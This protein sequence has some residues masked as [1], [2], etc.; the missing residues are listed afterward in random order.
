MK[1]RIFRNISSEAGLN[2]FAGLFEGTAFVVDP[3]MLMRAI[4]LLVTGIAVCPAAMGL[5]VLPFEMGAQPRLAPPLSAAL[6]NLVSVKQKAAGI[7]RARM[8]SDEVFLRRLLSKKSWSLGL[9]PAIPYE[10]AEK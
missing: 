3:V 9:L 2:P 8:C 6:D 7:R 4:L 1:S 10:L 5:T